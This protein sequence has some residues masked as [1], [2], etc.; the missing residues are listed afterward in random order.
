MGERSFAVAQRAAPQRGRTRPV[1]QLGLALALA[2]FSLRLWLVTQKS[3]TAMTRKRIPHTH[4]CHSMRLV[5][6]GGE[7]LSRTTR[8]TT[9]PFVNWITCGGK[10]HS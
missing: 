10:R 5:G 6:S 7:K 3:P 8:I 9:S 4:A 1:P 2:I